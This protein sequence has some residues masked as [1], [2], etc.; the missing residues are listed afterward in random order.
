MRVM[1]TV[2]DKG[3]KVV[4]RDSASSHS[5][6]TAENGT[7]SDSY[8]M[9]STTVYDGED[10]PYET[11]EL[12]PE[13]EGIVVV[14]QGADN[15]TV[16]SKIYQTVKALFQVDAHKDISSKDAF[17][18]GNMKHIFRKNQMIVTA[19]A[20]MIAAAGY[21]NYTY[22]MKEDDLAAK[23][24]DEKK[25]DTVETAATTLSEDEILTDTEADMGDDH[26]GETVLTGSNS[27]SIDRAAELKLNREQTR[28]ANKASL[29]EV[30]NNAALTDGEKTAAVEELAKMS[31]ISERESACE[32][33]LQS[34]GFKEAVVSITDD[35]A[36]VIVNMTE[37]T[38]AQ[39]AQIEDAVQRKGNISQ[40]EY[41][42]FHYESG[43]IASLFCRAL[44]GRRHTYIE[45][46]DDNKYSLKHIAT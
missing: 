41:C 6:S 42:D 17:T 32:L 33:L 21:V 40:G 13:V 31:D 8:S 22:N 20:L 3:E 18:G 26:A 7:V 44:Q 25:E 45:N 23:A 36:D 15:I 46:R 35:S 28:A 27:V 12:L 24:V 19:L 37:I 38:D 16:E 29:T 4:A 43:E 34:K 5:S 11:K 9:D 14:A 39:R 2:K 30:I 1:I 10:M